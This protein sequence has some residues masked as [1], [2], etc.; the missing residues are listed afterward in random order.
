MPSQIPSSL[1]HGPAVYPDFRPS[2][3]YYFKQSATVEQWYPVSALVGYGYV[4]ATNFKLFFRGANDVNAID[5]VQITVASGTSLTDAYEWIINAPVYQQ[6]SP[7]Y[8]HIIRVFVFGGQ[9]FRLEFTAATITYGTCC[10]GGGS[11]TM[12]H[13]TIR[14]DDDDDAQIDNNEFLKVTM[15]DGAAG[16]NL[17]GTGTTG[18]PY[19][20][21]LT[22]PGDTVYTLPL[23]T[24]T[25][26]GGVELGSNTDLTQTYETGG[27][28]TSGRT[29]PVQLN[30]ADQMGVSVPWIDTAVVFSTHVTCQ[31]DSSLEAWSTV[32]LVGET[33][34][35][36]TDPIWLAS[37][38][39]TP[40]ATAKFQGLQVATHAYT[41]CSA[42]GWNTSS[43]TAEAISNLCDEFEDP[44]TVKLVLF[45]GTPTDGAA[46][47][48][49]TSTTLTTLAFNAVAGRIQ[50]NAGSDTITM[51]AGDVFCLGFLVDCGDGGIFTAGPGA[52]VCNYTARLWVA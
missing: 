18:D 14:D 21:A 17:S 1:P 44:T 15:A 50:N 35:Y 3:V 32:Y 24:T 2:Y 37:L 46:T 29:Y 52:F 49:L 25:V 40:A 8:H 22:S 31:I 5:T 11:G 16:T 27:T 12:T 28:G 10:T 38:T 19:V 9:G 23:A 7:T 30:S 33:Y 45:H 48:T 6:V 42:Y 26:R 4:N 13:W 41:N 34:R 47:I 20:L 39:N 51:A 36:H 43:Q